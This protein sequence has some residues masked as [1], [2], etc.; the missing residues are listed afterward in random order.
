MKN[1]FKFLAL[2]FFISCKADYSRIEKAINDYNLSKKL[3][4]NDITVKS[5]KDRGKSRKIVIYEYSPGNDLKSQDTLTI[6]IT[7][8]GFVTSVTK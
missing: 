4:R 5:V 6:Y 3:Y 2:I 8:D 7:E 1:I